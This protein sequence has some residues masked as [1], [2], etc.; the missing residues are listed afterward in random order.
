LWHYNLGAS[1]IYA[2]TRDV[3]LMLEWVGYWIETPRSS[4][5]L[6]HEFVSQISPGVRKAFN[7]RNGSQLVAGVAVPLGVNDRA[8]DYGVF[9][10]LSFE[11][12]FLRAQ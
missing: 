9:L 6:H 7:F 1:A 5:N 8:P 4:G 10:Y 11:H 3:H 2:A 12:S